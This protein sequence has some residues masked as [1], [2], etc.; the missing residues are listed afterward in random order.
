[1]KVEER[2]RKEMNIENKKAYHDYFVDEKIECGISLRGNE[3][4]SIRQGSCNIKEAWCQIQDNN[5]VIRG[6]HI[7]KWNTANMF[8]VDE[9]RERQLLVHKSE[10]SKLK[11]MVQEKGVTLIPLKVYF[12]SNGKCKVLVGVCRGKHNYD[13]RQDLKDKQIK[14]DIDRAVKGM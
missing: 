3:V 12:S 7:S 5:L 8:D 14:R 4:K 11:Q 9:R 13:K 10:I 2:Q 1:M 6:M